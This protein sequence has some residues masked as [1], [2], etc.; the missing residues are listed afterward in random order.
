M[1]RTSADV[2]QQNLLDYINS[3]ATVSAYSAALAKTQLPT[4]A[5]TPSWY[6]DFAYKLALAQ[7]HVR[8]WQG[9]ILPVLQGVPVSVVS[10]DAAIQ[11]TFTIL[12]TSL[13]ALKADPGNRQLVQTITS[14]AGS[15]GQNIQQVQTTVEGM[16]EN[17]TTFA[18]N[19]VPDAGALSTLAKNALTAS[20]ADQDSVAQLNDAIQNLQNLIAAKNRVAELENLG[21]ADLAIFLVVV[22]ATVGWLGGPVVDGLLGMAA[23]GLLAGFGDKLKTE[24]D[25]TQQQAD[26]HNIELEISS[27]NSQVAILQSVATSFQQLVQTNDQAQQAAS[28]VENM[29]LQP[30]DDISSS[31]KNLTAITTN[32]SLSQ[33]DQAISEC[34]ASLSA[35]NALIQTATQLAKVTYNFDPP[36]TLQTG[37]SKAA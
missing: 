7:S 30:M 27:I 13:T 18:G 28:T 5:Q 12:S 14:T 29:W 19:L 35:W 36:V 34:N 9:G 24:N 16:E 4:I 33:I 31:L 15:L 17:I 26:I 1:I 10:F 25:I 3:I 21:K 11:S 32:L 23:I 20:K 8:N 2:S 37:I 22:A 6:A